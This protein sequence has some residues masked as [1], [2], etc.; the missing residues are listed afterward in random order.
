MKPE[1]TEA[2]ILHTFAARERDK[3][4]VFLTPDHG[5]RKGWAY[6][7]RSL[8]SRFGAALEPLAKVRIGYVEKESEEVVRIE[9]VDLIRS[10]FPAQQQLLSSVAATYIAELVDTFAQANDPAERIY[11]LLDRTTESLLAG[12]PPIAVVAYAEVW[13]LRLAGIFPSTRACGECGGSLERPLRFD[14]RLQG[15]VCETCAGRDAET[16]PNDVA[17]A[18]DAMSRPVEEFASLPI[19]PRVVFELRSLAGSVR[20]YFLGHELKSFEVLASVVGGS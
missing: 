7:A 14:A 17:D 2:I 15:F 20:R 13:M 8:K 4:V 12:A 1:R 19:P 3:M 18:L 16:I 11:R 9:S 10:L 6:G 5:K